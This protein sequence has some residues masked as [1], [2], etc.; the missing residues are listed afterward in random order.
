VVLIQASFS[1]FNAKCQ[2]T[3]GYSTVALEP[4]NLLSPYFLLAPWDLS[5]AF[6]SSS[7]RA[8][9]LSYGVSKESFSF[10]LMFPGHLE[11]L[12]GAFL[13]IVGRLACMAFI[14]LLKLVQ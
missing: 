12:R 7:G 2:V 8:G 11:T 6:V 3:V 14:M 13:G 10:P 9:L 4:V 5:W 1:L